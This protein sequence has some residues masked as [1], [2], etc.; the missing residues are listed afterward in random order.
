MTDHV[1]VTSPARHFAPLAIILS[2]PLIFA[3]IF[4]YTS[5]VVLETGGQQGIF[6]CGS[7][8]SPNTD[9]KNICSV[10][11]DVERSKALYSGLSGVAL[12]GLGVV[13]MVR[14]GSRDEEEWDD[15]GPRPRRG[16]DEDIDLRA[17]PRR[18]RSRDDVEDR[19]PDIDE[20]GSQTR[21]ERRG[22]DGRRSLLKDDDFADP[23]PRRRADDD[24]SSDGWR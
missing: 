18:D 1:E 4:F 10:P 2:I 21:P 8:S 14:G 19:D 24:W 9:A 12:L 6:K 11:E 22:A 15:D 16:R 7:P 5:P 13:W 20:P 3:A 23:Q 17:E